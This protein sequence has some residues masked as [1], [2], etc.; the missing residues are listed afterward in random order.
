MVTIVIEPTNFLER[1]LAMNTDRKGVKSLVING[2]TLSAASLIGCDLW[3]EAK[4][5][6]FQVVTLAPESLQSEKFKELIKDDLFCSRWQV[7]TVDEAHL[8]NQWGSEFRPLYREIKT[9]H[10]HVPHLTLVA[11]SAS[12]EP[13][14]QT[15]RILENLGFEDGHFYFDKRDTRRTNVIIKFRDVLFTHT[16]SIF[17]DL[18]WTIPGDMVKATDIPKRLIYFPTIETGHRIV[19]YL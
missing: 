8:S 14:G 4:E 11:L 2:D 6:R 18:D 12:V 10:S 16:S 13:G 1:S 9:I 17:R 5:C 19:H 7:L 15:N 3:Q